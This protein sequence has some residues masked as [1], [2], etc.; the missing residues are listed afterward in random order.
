MSSSNG[1]RGRGVSNTPA[2]MTRQSPP[3][4][5]S[6]SGP[7]PSRS[8]I[9]RDRD[10]F[11]RDP[12]HSS[13]RHY[14]NDRSSHYD[15]RSRRNRG[16]PPPSSSRRS[17]HHGGGGGG[18]RSGI[19]FNS[20]SEERAWLEYRRRKRYERPSL[21]DVEPTPEQAAL[22]ELSKAAFLK[23]AS[24]SLASH[25]A[26]F[27]REDQIAKL[28]SQPHQT[29]HAR[30]LYIGN[31]SP[32]L[33]EDDVH[34]F[35]RNAIYQAMGMDDQ[36]SRSKNKRV[37]EDDEDDPIL[38]T[39]INKER[40]FAFL[41]FKSIE[42]CTACLAFD[43]I[44]VCGEG[45]VKIKRP[46]DFNPELL[47]SQTDDNV[48]NDI[49]R[50]FDVSRLGIISPSVVDSPNKL[51]IG[52]LPYHLNEQ[53]VMELLSAFGSIKAF[54]LVKADANAITSKGYCFVEYADGE[55]VRDVAILGLNGMDMG[56]GKVL[57]ARIATSS[58]GDDENFETSNIS[59][60]VGNVAPI[61]PSTTAGII[62]VGNTMNSSFSP[63]IPTISA[64]GTSGAHP[65]MRFVDGVDIEALVDVAMGIS[66][67][68]AIVSNN[69]TNSGIDYVNSSA[70]TQQEGIYSGS[71]ASA[72]IPQQQQ[73]K[74]AYQYN[75][76]SPPT[77]SQASY[78]PTNASNTNSN[79]VLD[80]A[81]AALEAVFGNKN[82]TVTTNGVFLPTNSGINGSTTAVTT[83]T[84][85]LVL[86]NMV[87]EEDFASDE[88]YDG[89]VDEVRE[90][91]EKF[92]KLLSMKIPRPQDGYPPSS[93][94]KIFLEY[95]TI[96]D[97][98][99]AEQELAGRQFGAA[100]VQA[101]YFNE[102]DY[103]SGKLF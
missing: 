54:H 102:T 69:G 48:F 42:M 72:Y 96:D 14:D 50:K 31:L 12:Y 59:S 90:E 23:S 10:S 11:E 30:R 99:S 35:F 73:Q 28:T 101:T 83:K 57:S 91:C 6:S 27:V 53:Q 13:N 25:P 52:G 24:S 64:S 85:I 44:D 41:E 94:K 67:L 20:L 4:G 56:G 7:P 21:F 36:L 5:S 71:T 2:W 32:N 97:A 92:G 80:I 18:N 74:S 62:P 15:H 19:Y 9:D 100:V 37:D 81:N 65:I 47:P 34:I 45:K 46:N 76:P 88:D 26:S 89:L 43:G 55:S 82:A 38:N 60:F 77:T 78:F 61:I 66:T 63:G 1:G 87:T 16:G 17:G 29:R 22:E 95:A 93:L 49:L 79:Q 86:L 84:R 70:Q 40:R 103:A 58:R 39:Y 75:I 98:K 3:E 33:S 8:G 51:F 68:S